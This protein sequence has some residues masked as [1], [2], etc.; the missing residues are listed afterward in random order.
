MSRD[1]GISSPPGGC[2]TFAHPCKS[3]CSYAPLPVFKGCQLAMDDPSDAEIFA[4]PVAYSLS[5][6]F[7]T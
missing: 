7:C 1:T 3:D 4:F 6:S 5:T 2:L